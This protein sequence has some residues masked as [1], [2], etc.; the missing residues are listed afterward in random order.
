METDNIAGHLRELERE[1]YH[2][3]LHLMTDD[4]LKECISAVMDLLSTLEIYRDNRSDEGA[5][6]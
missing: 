3:H 4:E 5:S 1:I 6:S 2:E